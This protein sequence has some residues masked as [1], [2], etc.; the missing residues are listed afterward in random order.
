METK[1]ENCDCVLCRNNHEFEIS[2]ELMRE[3]LTGNVTVFAGAG[4]S[5]ETRN[6]LKTTFYESVAN[7][8]GKDEAYPAFPELM[9]EYCRQPNGR[10]KLLNR[11]KERF[12][13]ID[14]FPELIRSATR[15]HR[16][17]GTFF[18]IRNIVTTNWD[19]YFEKY[20]QAT[21]FV[22]DPDLAFWEAADRRVLKIHGSV[23]NYGSIVATTK[24]YQ[25]CQDRLTSGI[26][27]AVLKTIL[28][29][30]TVIFIG[31]SLSDSDFS[32][33]YEFVKMQMNALHKQACVVTPFASECEKFRASGFI[34]IQTD[35]A[36][37]ISQVKAHAVAQGEL[38]D[39]K[40]FDSAVE[41]L[42]S[43]QNEHALLHD[44]VKV[45]DFPEM[46]FAASYQDGLMHALER[47]IK[48]K[49]SGMYS[50]RCKVAGVI[51][52]Y[53][54]LQK[55]KLRRRTYED[56][57]YIEG[58]IN[59]LAYLLMTKEE[60]DSVRVPMY[61]V[62]GVKDEISDIAGFTEL[63]RGSPAIHKAAHKRALVYLNS[64]GDPESTE[65]HHPPWL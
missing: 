32:A 49:G 18:P 41:L 43:V 15:F 23:A 6:V 28:A 14:S 22:T 16:E 5:T 35:G 31:Y 34:P 64:L 29:T 8:I 37:F 21:P 40:I 24:D 42:Y 1:P 39:D 46:I 3:L 27:G 10:L 33:I 30:Q 48:L 17:L 36:Y 54:K 63:L 4:I 47:A 65:F 12:D 26:I 58:Y 20:C 56:V 59:G 7:E 11:I 45:S 60:R 52:A 53:L 38:L 61:F 13:H 19:T 62:F 44:A 50:H 25:Q 51:K 9:E 2:D 57:A 55:E